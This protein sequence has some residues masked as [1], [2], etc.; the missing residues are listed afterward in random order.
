MKG[1]IKRK[2]LVYIAAL[3]K[4]ERGGIQPVNQEWI[5]GGAKPLKDQ[6]TLRLAAVGVANLVI[7]FLMLKGD[8]VLAAGF[9]GLVEDLGKLIPAALAIALLPVVNGLIGSQ[10][11]ARLV[12]W[13]WNN[14]LP[15]CRAFSEH[16]HHDP[17]FDIGALERK[18]G[19]LPEDEHEQ[20]TTWFRLYR[21]VESVPAV[22]HTHRDF[23]F[24][25][26]YAALAVLFLVI[27]GGFSIFQMKDWSRTIDYVAFLAAQYLIVRYVAARYG[28]RFVTTVLAVKAAEN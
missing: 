12:F 6:N 19:K 11:K 9:K 22:S 5:H 15:G 28:Y 18:L 8:A 25:R 1:K 27:L 13:R 23:L 21:T 16:A 14:P 2:G 24:T 3:L 26:D 7:F 4:G 20:N 17:R 10:T